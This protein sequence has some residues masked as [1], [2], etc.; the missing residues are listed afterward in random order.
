MFIVFIATS[1]LFYK[2][3]QK[4]KA[5]FIQQKE[6]ENKQAKLEL[7]AIY[8]Q[9]NPH[10][11]FNAL[12][13]I[14]SLLNKKDIERANTYLSE[15][16]SLLRS[17]LKSTERELTPLSYELQI[18]EP[19]LSLEQLRFQF[20]YTITIDES[21]NIN[22]VE[23]PSLLLQPL[24]ENA[25]KHG[26]SSLYEKGEIAILFTKFQ[27]DLLLSIIDNGL[28]YNVSEI[29][30]GLGLKLTKDRIHLLNQTLNVNSI[31]LMIES[32]KNKGTTV[33][34]IFKN[35]L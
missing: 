13:S 9:L 1:I 27:K 26:I 29:S 11:I 6:N 31:E 4:R 3:L 5:N 16:S 28:G 20:K 2:I 25:I 12:A 23:I 33:H 17:A 21:I 19:Y 18:I 7:K 14:Q 10:F 32:A 8:S 30:T 34:L 22:E 35:W 24:V 15:F